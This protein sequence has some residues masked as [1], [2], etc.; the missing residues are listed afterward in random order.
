MARYIRFTVTPTDGSPYTQ[1]LN[2][3]AVNRVTSNS[4]TTFDNGGKY[5]LGSQTGTGGGGIAGNARGNVYVIP[6]SSSTALDVLWSP[7]VW[8]SKALD[9]LGSQS[10]E[11]IFIDAD[12][13]PSSG[14][15]GLQSYVP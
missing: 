7:S 3:D 2:A 4:I 10:P 5:I 8:W 12:G 11:V 13:S 15:A 14:I 1:W 9:K 6:T